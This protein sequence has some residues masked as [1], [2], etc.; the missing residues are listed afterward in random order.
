M[1]SDLDVRRATA[2][3]LPAVLV[4]LR[5][6]LGWT[7]DDTRF[8]EWKHLENPNGSSPMW[9]AL[10]GARVV[11]F[12]AFLRWELVTPSGRLRR[13]ARAVDT[14]TDPDYQGRGVFTRL[15]GD[16]LDALRDD[17]VDLVF[18]T[19]NANSLP[20]YRRL[21]WREL[22]RLPTAVR[23]TRLRFLA[24]VGTARRAASRAPV[25]TD[26]GVPAAAGLADRDAVRRLLE[27]CAPPAGLTTRRTPEY[28]AWRYGWEELG[29]RLLLHGPTIGEGFLVYRHRRRGRA[30]EGVVAEVVVPEGDRR[31]AR[32]LL[33]RLA[34]AR[35]VDYLVRIQEPRVTRDAFVRLPQVGP[36]LVCRSLADVRVPDL[37][38]WAL[39]MGDVELL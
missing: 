14:A 27:T 22:G 7:D 8:L 13:A 36:V 11:G 26:G 9:I 16:A 1:S 20:G 23:P 28:L 21:G 19:P 25:R 31:V 34:R 18:N 2:D 5:R 6:A 35:D 32:T 29:Y 4:L 10:D 38:G 33:S 17:G 30:V 37:S 15:T 12:R 3:D 24:V 39:G